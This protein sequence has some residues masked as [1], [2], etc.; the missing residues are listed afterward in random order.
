MS[1]CRNGMHRNAGIRSKRDR[2]EDGRLR[3]SGSARETVEGPPEYML[4]GPPPFIRPL[5]AVIRPLK[6]VIRP[7]KACYKTAQGCV[8][9]G[10]GAFGG[11]VPR[12]RDYVTTLHQT[13]CPK[14]FAN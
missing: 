1:A 5:K 3:A 8:R 12:R 2:G 4:V 11:G 10:A 9:A 6:A 13:A 14:V 7:L